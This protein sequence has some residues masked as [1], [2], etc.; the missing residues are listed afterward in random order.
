[1]ILQDALAP[2]SDV[3]RRSEAREI[4][5]VVDEVGLVKIP[6]LRRETCPVLALLS[7]RINSSTC[8]KRRTRQNSLGDIPTSCL[9]TWMNRRW[10]SPILCA[11]R[12]TVTSDSAGAK[13]SDANRTA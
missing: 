1:V 5:K 2:L 10:L 3:F 9:K 13:A 11:T 8:W 6:A 12:P 7:S 4:P